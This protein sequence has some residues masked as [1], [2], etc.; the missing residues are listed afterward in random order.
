MSLILPRYVSMWDPTL[1]LVWLAQI[2]RGEYVP[3]TGLSIWIIHLGHKAI[4]YVLRGYSSNTTTFFQKL[5][6]ILLC[7]W[8]EFRI[9]QTEEPT[10]ILNILRFCQAGVF[11]DKYSSRGGVLDVPTE[12]PLVI[13]SKMTFFQSHYQQNPLR[14]LNGNQECRGASGRVA[15]RIPSRTWLSIPVSRGHPSSPVWPSSVALHHSHSSLWL[16]RCLSVLQRWFIIYRKFV[17]N[18]HRNLPT[19]A[20]RR[21]LMTLL[22][23]KKT[24][25]QAARWR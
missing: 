22:E 7:I 13:N 15:R 9:L 17:L 11:Q 19:A 10:G 14:R 2:L 16:F 20:W 21:R 3:S 4:L 12:T 1:R 6:Q 25:S 8:V 23:L 5:S 24:N 18:N